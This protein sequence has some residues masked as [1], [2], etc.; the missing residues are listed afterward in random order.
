MASYADIAK[1]KQDKWK[2]IEYDREENAVQNGYRNPD[3]YVK[4]S[5]AKFPPRSPVPPG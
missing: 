1:F 5:V 2:K 3:S 4:R